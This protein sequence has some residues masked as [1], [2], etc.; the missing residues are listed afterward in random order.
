MKPSR[1][2]VPEQSERRIPAPAP[3]MTERE[4]E[5][6]RAV[7]GGKA[8]CHGCDGRAMRVVKTPAGHKLCCWDDHP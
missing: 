8:T 4:R 7:D 1:K 2:P 6:W 5:L 3:A